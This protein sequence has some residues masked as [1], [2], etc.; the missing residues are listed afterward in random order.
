MPAAHPEAL[1]RRVVSTY[2]S[3]AG[4]YREIAERF[5]VSTASVNRWVQQFRRTQSVR[6]K[7]RGKDGPR[8]IDPDGDAF[9]IETLE[10]VPDSTAPELVAAYEE[11]FGV[12]VSDATMKRTIS[13]LG[14]TRK[15]GSSGHRTRSVR[16]FSRPENAS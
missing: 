11:V 6:A 12:Q 2:L 7:V 8:L 15:R 4:T 9:I 3:G 5:Q 14:F 16:T 10:A 13:R 1:R